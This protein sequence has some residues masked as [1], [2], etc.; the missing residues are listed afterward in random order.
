M[1]LSSNGASFLQKDMYFHCLNRHTWANVYFSVLAIVQGGRNG[2]QTRGGM[3]CVLSLVQMCSQLVHLK[4]CLKLQLMADHCTISSAWETNSNRK[5]SKGE[6]STSRWQV[7]GVMG[8]WFMAKP[9]PM[10]NRHIKGIL[11]AY[12]RCYKKSSD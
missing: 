12:V 7:K 9:L 11:T 5:A 3:F 8:A 10:A 2:R 4:K 1:F 6:H